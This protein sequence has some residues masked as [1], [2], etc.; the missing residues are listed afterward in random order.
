MATAAAA[1]AASV[2]AN[3]PAAAAAT[4]IESLFRAHYRR[5]CRLTCRV[6]GDP[7]LAEELAAE[8]FWK[9]HQRPPARLTPR[10][11]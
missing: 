9:L 1:A 11:G 5:L 10:R 3:H 8:A 2:A 6:I 7:D 4:D